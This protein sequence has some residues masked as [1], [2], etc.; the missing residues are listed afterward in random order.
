MSDLPEPLVPPDCDLRGLQYMP[1]YGDRLFTSETWL[2]ARP[3]AKVAMTQ[4]WWHSYAHEAPAASL[5]DNDALLA[6][7]AGY[8][9]ARAQWR[10]V[11]EE[12][13][14]GWV[15]CSDGR[16]YHPFVARLALEAW[17]GRLRNR[18][19]QRRWRE[20]TRLSDRDATVKNS[21][22]DTVTRPLRNAGEGEGEGYK[23]EYVERVFD[24]LWRTW[25]DVARKRHPQAKVRD[26]IRG[27]LKAGADPEAIIAAGTAHV[28][29][30]TRDGKPEIVKGLVPWLSSGLWRNWAP[31][32][33]GAAAPVD[34]PLR[35][36]IWRDSG[37]QEWLERWGP[38]PGTPG[39][40]GPSAD[41][42]FPPAP[43]H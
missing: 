9:A 31:S 30:R 22:Y 43:P 36:Q 21:G 8:G 2:S 41:D 24:A 38:Q 26:A 32:G 1:L 3:E 37:G 5:P 17:A 35:M 18:D 40:Q 16:L 23:K 15:M 12:A 6:S 39:F 28:A 42:L 20:K 25:P 29:E 10:K 34:W 14:R 4:L 7:Y 11:K 33:N 13:M 27:Q 19:K